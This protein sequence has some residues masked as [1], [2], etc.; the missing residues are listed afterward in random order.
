MNEFTSSPGYGSSLVSNSH[1][2]IPYPIVSMLN[3]NVGRNLP[4]LYTSALSNWML[5]HSSTLRVQPNEWFLV[6]HPRAGYTA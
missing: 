4:K 6:P 2:M 3:S 5:S 1:K